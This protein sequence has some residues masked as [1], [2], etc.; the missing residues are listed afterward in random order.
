MAQQEALKEAL[1]HGDMLSRCACAMPKLSGKA[2]MDAG[3]DTLAEQGAQK[4]ALEHPDALLH[5]CR[6]LRIANASRIAVVGST[7]L[8]AA[9]QRAIRAADTVLR[10][11]G[12]DRRYSLSGFIS[13]A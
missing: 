12:V 7:A 13:V 11:D 8:S 1:D 6:R 10:F 3:E 9:E 2:L 4:E 5:L